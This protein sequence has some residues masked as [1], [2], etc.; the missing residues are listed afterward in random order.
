MKGITMKK[1]LALLFVLGA[2][3]NFTR[4]AT[5]QHYVLPAYVL[6]DSS[7]N[8][9]PTGSGTPLGYT[10]PGFMCYTLVSGSVVPCTFSG[11][12]SSGFPITLG[13]TSIA[14]GSTTTALTGLSVNGVTLSTAGPATAYL[15]QS[16]AYTT[17]AG[18]G[19]PGGST[20]SFQYNNAGAFG[21]V[22]ITGFVYGN[23]ASA[24]T[25]A[26]TAQTTTTINT[27]PCV[28]GS[29]C[30]ITATPPDDIRFFLAAV[31]D[32]GTAFASDFTRY[33]NQQPQ[34]GSELPASSTSAYMA[35]Q[36]AASPLQY[37]QL[38]SQAT[39]FPWLGTSA[40]IQ[41]S[42]TATTGNVT[43][44]VATACVNA[45]GI[46]S[47]PTFGTPVSVTTTVSGTAGALVTTAVLTNI[48]V[49]GTNGC[50]SGTTAPGSTLLVRI[51]RGA[52]DTAASDAHFYGMTLDTVR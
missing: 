13:S 10:P 1:I 47:T 21:G 23:G 51:N 49:P 14:S 15:N 40:Y 6:Y 28:L 36:Q 18:G 35:F 34:T 44:Q 52:S 27:Q 25:Q 7:G 22:N 31:S 29:S 48:A 26:S 24:P 19:T 39:P 8:P 38:K 16:G 32:G 4:V 11:G 12:G 33:D 42:T 41:F 50:V 43:W 46:L 3:I 5:A 2:A 37:A 45:G 30:T 9:F 20:G 17:P